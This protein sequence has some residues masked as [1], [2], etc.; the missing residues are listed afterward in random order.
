MSDAHRSIQC[1]VLC[2]LD[3]SPTDPEGQRMVLTSA[4]AWYVEAARAKV[5]ELITIVATV[6]NDGWGQ[7][8][9]A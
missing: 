2:V 1:P 6:R 4:G 9:V 5:G 8:E 3:E 7:W